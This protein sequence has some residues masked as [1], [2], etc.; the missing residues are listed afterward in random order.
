MPLHK[1]IDSFNS[2]ELSPLMGSRLGVEKTASGC[3]RL[4]NFIPLVAGPAM[5][6]GGL[7]YLAAARSHTKRSSLR[8]FNF[9]TSVS[10]VLEFS[11]LGFRVIQNGAVVPLVEDVP[12]PFSEQDCFEVQTVQV[13]D[14]IYHTHA[15]HHPYKFIRLA[16]NRWVRDHLFRGLIEV[17]TPAGVDTTAGAQ[18]KVRLDYY[19]P[20]TITTDVDGMIADPALA[21]DP[22]G[23]QDITDLSPP[24]VPVGGNYMRKITGNLTVP[25]SGQWVITLPANARARVYV[26]G[27]EEITVDQGQPEASGTLT[28]EAGAEYSLV[29]YNWL[30]AGNQDFKLSIEGPS[31]ARQV[32]PGSM[33]SKVD[34]FSGG[35]Y[36]PSD[37]GNAWPPVLD[38][39]V[40][41][42]TIAVSA[43]AGTGLT[44]SATE[45]IFKP[46]H[47]GSFWQIAHTRTVSHVEIVGAVGAF[48]GT[49]GGLFVLGPWNL[50]TYGTWSGTLY[51]QRL[52][53]DGVTWENI[54]TWNSNKDRNVIADGSE[55]VA[56]QLRLV[57]V[58]GNGDA[59]STASV[60]RF[61]LE[62]ADARI[63][64]LIYVTAVSGDG[65]SATVDVKRDILSTA[66]TGLWA[67]GAWSEERGYPRAV[68]LHKGSMYYGGTR[69]FPSRIWK[70]AAGDWENF[71]ITSLADG[72]ID[73][74]LAAEES[75]AIQWM[76]S[77]GASL[78]IG[79]AGEEWS[80]SPSS[81]ETISAL[82]IS[83][84]R[85]SRY[86]SAYL[87]ATIVNDVPVFVQRG[88]RKV[89]KLLYNES[90]RKYAASDLTVLAE[91][92][93]KGG[94]KGLAFQSQLSAILWGFTGEGQLIGMTHETEQNVFGWHRHI[95]DGD[96]ESACVI[97]GSAGT[98]EL[99][100]V[101]R[102]TVDAADRRFIERMDLTAMSQNF[103]DPELLNY[104]D[105]SRH[106][107]FT[108]AGTIVPG[109]EHLEGRVVSLLVDGAVHPDR[110]VIDGAVTLQASYPAETHIIA[111]LPFTSLLQPMKQEMQ[112]NDGSAQGRGMKTVAVTV[113]Y[114][115]SSGGQAADDPDRSDDLWA[116]IFSRDS[117][118][119]M[120]AAPPLESDERRVVLEAA[121]RKSVNVA[122][123]QSLPLPLCVTALI[124][125]TDVYQAV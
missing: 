103:D 7:E 10:A 76:C 53:A 82:S 12:L 96:I 72:A 59:A 44:A 13:N 120:G 36:N 49:S 11:P 124:V 30:N 86:G 21:G 51:L 63:Y 45:P 52:S 54:R 34:A 84:E 112:M 89:R 23:G 60:P 26:D 2:G 87:P 122:V 24:V 61:L 113:R 57:V 4:E 43:I 37:F 38:E 101:V 65:L 9:S 42:T 95:T 118:L 31:F 16:S 106:H 92:I 14:I 35:T 46:G 41:P 110:A 8:P 102:R 29:I 32:V 83:V 97:Y 47:I 58:S 28:L 25:T 119:P 88:G 69:S 80:L 94:V 33:L 74:T 100:C 75:N 56:T 116:D 20:F 91:H 15:N 40:T 48:S 55:D 73:I 6:R 117:E 18:G 90:E 98:D 125:E 105:S 67:E 39:N 123:R 70:S 108:T 99:Y 64:G 104:L 78:L 121:T 50:Y 79:T 22:D 5:R 93:T 81:G 77:Q 66:A 107:V 115:E 27:V 111:G 114:H 1:I 19:Q 71:R 109:L 3:R 68:A 17:G 85:Q 62:A